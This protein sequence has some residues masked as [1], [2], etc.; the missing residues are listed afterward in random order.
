[1]FDRAGL[2][3]AEA[4]RPIWESLVY[5]TLVLFLVDV[6]IR[7]IAVSPREMS[8]KARAYV[9]E[10]AHR[11]RAAAESEAVLS[12]LK[13]TRDRVRQERA[14]AGPAPGTRYEPPARDRPSTDALGKALGGATEQDAPV[15]ARPTGKKPAESEADYTARLLKAKRRARDEMKKDL[16]ET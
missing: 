12:T 14:E 1:V 8:R 13:G 11:G 4:Q 3:Q 2:N 15:V 9:E 7:R 6:A 10:M 16:D 5:W